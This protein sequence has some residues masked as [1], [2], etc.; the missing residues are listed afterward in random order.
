VADFD[1]NIRRA[2]ENDEAFLG[3]VEELKQAAT[4]TVTKNIRI[5]TPCAKCNCKHI[6]MVPVE[7]PDYNIKLKIMEFMT[8]RGVGRPNAADGGE[9]AERIT[10][11]RT[12]NK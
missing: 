10:F 6:R 5:D 7:V 12:V 2:L 4:A 11:I 3:L 1:E 8:N 9:T